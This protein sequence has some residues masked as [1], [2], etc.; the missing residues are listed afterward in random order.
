MAEVAAESILEDT[1]Q[2]GVL[3]IGP[4]DGISA[5]ALVIREDYRYT[6]RDWASLDDDYSTLTD[7]R[8]HLGRHRNGMPLVVDVVNVGKHF[9]KYLQQSEISN[10]VPMISFDDKSREPLTFRSPDSGLWHV[11]KKEAISTLH[12]LQEE[13]RINF[14]RRG[15][16]P[17]QE[18]V[19]RN[20]IEQLGTTESGEKERALWPL[21]VACLIAEREESVI[22][23]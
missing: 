14:G 15:V 2:V 18:E 9:V 22:P 21:A 3:Y 13:D 1:S 20:R 11:S 12:L 10:Y 7:D 4:P 19:F 8:D 6:A 23:S 5:Y 17:R 16:N